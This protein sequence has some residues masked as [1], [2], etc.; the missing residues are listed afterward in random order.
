MPQCMSRPRS[1]PTQKCQ[2]G[3]RDGPLPSGRK[4]RRTQRRTV[5]RRHCEVAHPSIAG[6]G[7]RNRG[8]PLMRP[9]HRENRG[10]QALERGAMKPRVCLEERGPA[11][12]QVEDGSCPEEVEHRTLLGARQ[13]AS[14]A[15]FLEPAHPRAMPTRRRSVIPRPPRSVGLQTKGQATL[16]L[17][18]QTRSPPAQ[19]NARHSLSMESMA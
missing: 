11:I 7:V 8:P 10:H 6:Q 3:P 9:H 16:H 19:R 14:V 2:A 18:P 12:P 17:P 5:G 4:G 15:V 13:H 1:A